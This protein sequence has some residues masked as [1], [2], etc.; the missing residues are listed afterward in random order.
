M[1]QLTKGE[2]RNFEAL[3]VLCGQLPALFALDRVRREFPNNS[4]FFRELADAL[5]RTEFFDPNS[6][7]VQVKEP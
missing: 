3:I 5:E 7:Q 2:A 4:E 6:A 1:P